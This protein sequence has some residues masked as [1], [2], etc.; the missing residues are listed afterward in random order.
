MYE[1]VVDPRRMLRVTIKEPAGEEREV[2]AVTCAY[3][4]AHSPGGRA[5]VA[6][7]VVW[8]PETPNPASAYLCPEDRLSRLLLP[9]VRVKRI[10]DRKS[11]V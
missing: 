4:P 10:R 8:D 1:V 2:A 9:P 5:S 3:V 7:E 6:I 11:V